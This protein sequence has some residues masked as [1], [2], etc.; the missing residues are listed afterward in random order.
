MRFCLFSFFFFLFSFFF[1]LFL[2]FLSLSL[3]YILHFLFCPHLC[4]A[5]SPFISSFSPYFFVPV[6]TEAKGVLDE[7][8]RVELRE[9][10]MRLDREF[11]IMLQKIAD[12][13]DQL[14]NL[15][16]KLQTLDRHRQAKEE[17][18]RDLERKLVVLLEEQQKELEQIK[19]R[20]ERRGERFISDDPESGAILASAVGG[21]SGGGGGGDGGRGY[22]GPSQQQQQQAA[23]LMQSTETLMKFGFMS[24]SLT[25]F[26]SL[27]MIRAMRATGALETI[28]AGKNVS[29]GPMAM[30]ATAGQPGAG[31]HKFSPTL[32]GA[33][34]PGQEEED[35]RAWSVE[36]VGE[37]LSSLAL[38]QYRESFADAAVD[39]AFLLDLNDEDLRNTLGIDHALHRKKIINSVRRLAV[40]VQAARVAQGGVVSQ[41]GGGG[42]GGG[43]YNAG[44]FFFFFLPLLC[45]ARYC[46]TLC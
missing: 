3:T 28:L 17:E 23:A 40:G 24:M 13:K 42:G 22:Q 45:L 36:D 19:Q 10:K 8:A 38:G 7:E 26:S 2:F 37:W 15:E 6:E 33:S 5:P 9:Q 34:L 20:Q 25:Y 18:L 32:K 43:G 41:V 16:G 29:G 21:G 46:Q 27:N 30:I 35:P 14:G 44:L 31:G 1:F 12:R 39:G 4:S 11:S